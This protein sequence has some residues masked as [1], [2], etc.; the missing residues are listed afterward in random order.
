MFDAI[1]NGLAV[2]VE[3]GGGLGRTD[4]GGNECPKPCYAGYG[5]PSAERERGLGGDFA[6]ACGVR[7]G[8]GAGDHAARAMGSGGARP[9]F[10]SGMPV[11]E[12]IAMMLPRPGVDALQECVTLALL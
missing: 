8:S 5:R 9:D 2:H 10:Q 12:R 11:S 7:D 4:G 3:D 6:K 1:R